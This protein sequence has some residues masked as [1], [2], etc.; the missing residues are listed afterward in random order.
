MSNRILIQVAAPTVFIG[1][2][3]TG[4][5]LLSAWYVNRL[6]TN[7]ASILSECFAPVES[8]RSRRSG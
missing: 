8:G 2:L 3:L 4:A 6:Q 7:Q 5:C 1:L